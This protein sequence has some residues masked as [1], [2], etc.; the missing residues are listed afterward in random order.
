MGLRF[1][2]TKEIRKWDSDQQQSN[3]TDQQRLS[4]PFQM[5]PV[6]QLQLVRTVSQT[7]RKHLFDWRASP[8]AKL[9]IME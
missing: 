5:N 3:R 1:G 4:Q 9:A 8:N 7:P 6:P 2:E